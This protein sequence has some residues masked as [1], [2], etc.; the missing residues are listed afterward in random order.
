MN[1][2]QIKEY[3]GEDRVKELCGGILIEILKLYRK[4]L[5]QYTDKQANENVSRFTL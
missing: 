2:L 5:K 3:V 4:K 1:I